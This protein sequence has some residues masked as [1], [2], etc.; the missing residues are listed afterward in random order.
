MTPHPIL[1]DNILH[2]A[3]DTAMSYTAFYNM[4]SAL[5]ADNNTSGPVKSEERI[6]ATKLNLQRLTRLNKTTQLLPEWSNLDITKTSNLQWVVITEAWC[7]DGSQ[8]VPVMNKVAEKLEISF[9]VV[10]RDSHPDLIDRYLFRGT[11]SIPRLI[12][13]NAETGEELGNWGPRPAEA[14]QLVDDSIAKGIPHDD[15][16]INLQNWYNQNK[17]VSLQNE[18]FSFVNDCLS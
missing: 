15:W 10:L 8:L 7:G 17:T 1:I 9:K 13:F 12:C 18:L 14:Q 3:I 6:Q 4:T 5:V 11:R 16:V 2:N